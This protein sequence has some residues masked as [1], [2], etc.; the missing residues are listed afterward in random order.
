MT[1]RIDWEALEKLGTADKD[2]LIDGILSTLDK[3]E[4]GSDELGEIQ[5]TLD[6]WGLL[7]EEDEEEEKNE[8][9]GSF[10]GEDD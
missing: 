7:K 10:A 4:W 5:E 2:I 6:N 9:A 8:A 3:D 1:H